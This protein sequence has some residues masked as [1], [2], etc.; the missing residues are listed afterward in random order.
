MR[1]RKILSD[2]ENILPGEDGFV[3]VHF[4]AKIQDQQRGCNLLAVFPKFPNSQSIESH[5]LL[6]APATSS[7]N[8][9]K[10]TEPTV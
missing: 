10:I 4:P 6:A 8:P 7:H 5:Q 9:C 2:L 3:E 1:S